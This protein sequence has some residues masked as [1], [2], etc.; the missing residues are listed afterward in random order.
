MVPL[1]KKVTS[2]LHL[3]QQQLKLLVGHPKPLP[4]LL[5][6]FIVVQCRALDIHHVPGSLS[7][8]NKYFPFIVVKVVG[9]QCIML[10]FFSLSLCW[11]H[12]TRTF[13]I[14]QFQLQKHISCSLSRAKYCGYFSGQSM[15]SSS[16]HPIKLVSWLS[17]EDSSNRYCRNSVCLC[18]CV[19]LAMVDI[20]NY[21][22]CAR[23]GSYIIIVIAQLFGTC[24]SP[25]YIQA[26][27][28]L[29]WL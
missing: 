4:K 24:Q 1:P 22:H 2:G 3:V 5:V 17:N 18:V 20:V 7:Q 16:R 15:P 29:N 23:V 13:Y 27:L 6:E 21:I 12:I 8:L 10:P 9:D 14:W 19:L 26:V 28:V 25:T 11:F